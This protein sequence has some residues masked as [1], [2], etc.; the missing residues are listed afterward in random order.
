MDLTAH[1]DSINHS[2]RQAGADGIVIITEEML[3]AGLAEFRAYDR[4][5]ASDEE[6]VKAIYLAME[7]IRR[8]IP[9]TF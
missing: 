2:D 4:R 8:V 6:A 7:E 5:F 3:E 1:D 9:S